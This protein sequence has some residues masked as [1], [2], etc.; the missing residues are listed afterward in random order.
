MKPST[1]VIALL[2][3]VALAALAALGIVDAATAVTP[4]PA[5]YHQSASGTTAHVSKG[6]F[7]RVDLRS[8]SGIPYE[9]VVVKG[10]HAH[11][12]KITGRTT[13]STTTGVPGAPFHTVWT[14]HGVKHGTST[15]KVVLRSITDHKDVARHF[16]LHVKVS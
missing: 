11:S 12:F 10:K 3:V 7:I 1:R 13:Y 5:T 6:S 4:A 14:L 15:F 2:L 16:V 9:W 8:P